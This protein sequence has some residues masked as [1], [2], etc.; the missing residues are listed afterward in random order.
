MDSDVICG[1]LAGLRQ[2][3]GTLHLGPAE[4]TQLRATMQHTSS[5]EPLHPY[6]LT[7]I[8]NQRSDD[9]QLTS[10]LISIR[11][12][13]L[14]RYL[15]HVSVITNTL[16]NMLELASET[17]YGVPFRFSEEQAVFL[18]NLFSVSRQTP[19]N[20]V[21][22]LLPDTMRSLFSQKLFSDPFESPLLSAL[23]LLS[24]V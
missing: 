24:V 13:T 5:S 11:E 10:P 17:D 3:S 8:L 19:D 14:N 22:T 6:P 9:T 2:L 23:A 15:K 12:E 18:T 4:K 1:W 20:T 21:Q 16:K 7:I